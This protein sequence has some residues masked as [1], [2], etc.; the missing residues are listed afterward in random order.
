MGDMSGATAAKTRLALYRARM[1]DGLPVNRQ[2]AIPSL[3]IKR[4]PCRSSAV[5]A[6]PRKQVGREL[7]G[8][9]LFTRRTGRGQPQV[10]IRRDHLAIE[11]PGGVAKQRDD[12]GKTKEERDRTCH[13]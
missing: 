10:R 11:M 2:P 3:S 13:Q 8:R 1:R 7:G 5:L 4:Y 9:S 12:D 6:P